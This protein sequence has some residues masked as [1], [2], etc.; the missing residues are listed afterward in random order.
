MWD[1]KACM[2]VIACLIHF[3]DLIKHWL[4]QGEIR[5]YKAS[6]SCMG[7]VREGRHTRTRAVDLLK[8]LVACEATYSDHKWL[9]GSAEEKVS[10]PK[11]SSYL[12]TPVS[13]EEMEGEVSSFANKFWSF[14]EKQSC[15]ILLHSE[16]AAPLAH[17]ESSRHLLQLLK[18]MWC[19]WSSTNILWTKPSPDLPSAESS[20]LISGR[21]FDPRLTERKEGVWLYVCIM[22]R[23]L[24]MS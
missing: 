12:L 3:R 1:E 17:F 16:E 14:T 15:N 5:S 4:I 23:R 8:L 19:L 6:K 21:S 7:V 10:R 9:L 20:I 24:W 22:W 2:H 13:D 18:E 11:R